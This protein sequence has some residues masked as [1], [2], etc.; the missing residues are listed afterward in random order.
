[1]PSVGAPTTFAVSVT[2]SLDFGYS[3]EDES[4]THNGVVVAVDVE[5][6][7]GVAVG[8]DVAVGVGV[9]VG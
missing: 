7:V 1:M 9:A 6:G 3:L 5:L 8:V 4:S 2:V